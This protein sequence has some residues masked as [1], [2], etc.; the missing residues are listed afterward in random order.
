MH[1]I[2]YLRP[3]D[4]HSTT[5]FVHR[6]QLHEMDVKIVTYMSFEALHFALVF[7]KS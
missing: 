3:Q 5:I 2:E 7:W 4:N 1:A 6:Q